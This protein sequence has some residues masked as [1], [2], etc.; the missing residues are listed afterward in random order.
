VAG[1]NLAGAVVAVAPP[2]DVVDEPEAVDFDD[3]L[4]AARQRAMTA[5][6]DTAN[7]CVR[8]GVFRIIQVLLLS[9]TVA[10]RRHPAL[11]F[12]H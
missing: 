7:R 4:H 12:E 1:A 8:R 3:E 2:P 5:T 6:S 11:S 9:A 10:A